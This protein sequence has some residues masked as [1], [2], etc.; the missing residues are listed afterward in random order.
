MTKILYCI[1]KWFYLPRYWVNAKRK[2]HQKYGGYFYDNIRKINVEVCDVK[3][4]SVQEEPNMKII[5]L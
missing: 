5:D 2:Y 1:Y 3:S 4:K